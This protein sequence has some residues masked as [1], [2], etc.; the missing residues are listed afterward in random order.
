MAR[1]LLFSI[2]RGIAAG[3]K[4]KYRRNIWEQFEA[5]IR[6]AAY[7]S[8]LSRFLDSACRKM[9]SEI[10][11]RCKSDVLEILDCEHSPAI[12]RL[13]R[14]ETTG[15]VLR[16]RLLNDDRRERVQEKWQE[17]IRELTGGDDEESSL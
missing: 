14:D 16:V 8:D 1:K 9:G 6:S 4:E 7:T 3:Y 11:S 15:L 13:L 5:G 10:P 17:K 2:W 12:L